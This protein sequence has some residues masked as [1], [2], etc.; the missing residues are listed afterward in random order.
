[1]ACLAAQNVALLPFYGCVTFGVDVCEAL[2]FASPFVFV[3]VVIA[4][5][6]LLSLLCFVDEGQTDGQRRVQLGDGVIL[7]VQKSDV[8]DS[9][10]HLLVE[11]ADGARG[12]RS[13]QS[14]VGLVDQVRRDKESSNYFTLNKKAW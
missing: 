5:T 3:L 7:A 4:Q 9:A 8:Q 14:S 13:D 11:V 6:F 10:G 12:V 2:V 1:M